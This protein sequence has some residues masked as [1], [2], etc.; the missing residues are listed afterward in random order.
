MGT[1]WHPMGT[2]Q[3]PLGT[4]WD[5]TGRMGT[6]QA[7]NGTQW[8]PTGPNSVQQDPTASK[9]R[10]MGPNRTQRHLMGTQQH[11]TGPN[12]VQWA[13][14]RTQGCPMGTQE[15]PKGAQQGPTAPHGDAPVPPSRPWCHRDPP[16]LTPPLCPPQ[17]YERSESEEVAFITQL[18]KRLLII[19]SRPARLLECLVRPPG[20]PAPT[21]PP[22]A[23][24]GPC[25]PHT[26]TLH[27]PNRPIAAILPRRPDNAPANP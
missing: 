15:A 7:P 23:M 3:D 1:Q 11:P 18:V 10:S 12:G 26:H 6:Q 22:P 13:P 19:I 16:P 14:S 24:G 25:A 8:C 21:F 17:A 2:Q 4:Q 5:P 27:H 9:G 20:P